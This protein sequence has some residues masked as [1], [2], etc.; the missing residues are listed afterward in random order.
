APTPREQLVQ[1]ITLVQ[2]EPPPPPPP[3]QKIEPREVLKPVERAKPQQDVE[4]PSEDP[5]P[6][7]DSL[8]PAGLDR[9][10]DAGADSFHLAAGKGGGFFGRGGGGGGSWDAYVATHIRRALQAD[11]RTRS[12]SGYLEVSLLIASDGRFDRADLQSS[13]GNAALD[14]AI[15]DVLAHLQPLSRSRP[16]GVPGLVVTGINLRAAER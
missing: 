5:S 12:A 3:P 6:P 1:Q 4:H 10:A 14:A 11:P 13:T 7:T 9:P 8:E 2:E 16:A 15:R